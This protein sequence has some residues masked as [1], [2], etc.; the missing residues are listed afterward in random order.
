MKIG[1]LI[2]VVR[3]HRIML[4]RDLATLYCVPTGAL[5]RAVKRNSGRFP[6]DFMFR[7][8]P[9]EAEI[10]K[11]QIGI[12]SWGGDRSLPHAFTEQGVAM[13]SSVLR[14]ER[15]VQVNVS[16]MRAFVRLRQ[17]LAAQPDLADRIE[18]AE[19][20]LGAHENELGEHAVQIHEVF[21]AIKRMTCET[22]ASSATAGRPGTPRRP[23]GAAS[24]SGRR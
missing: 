12:S 23:R 14:S 21:A 24:R 20:M 18:K 8:E 5:N 15:A 2:Y 10:L 17:V 3:G 1:G 22:A 19:R 6:G 9:D 16:I 4:D 11:C 7:L 13:L